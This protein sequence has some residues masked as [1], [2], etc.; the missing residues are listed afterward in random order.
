MD[1]KEI[2]RK[3]TKKYQLFNRSKNNEALNVIN[4]NIK[5]CS[6][7]KKD[8]DINQFGKSKNHEKTGGHSKKCLEC[9][10]KIRVVKNKRPTSYKEYIL[11]AVARGQLTWEYIDTKIITHKEYKD[12]RKTFKK[13]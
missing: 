6:C 10:E 12:A 3:Y 8:L 7:C 9:E 5:T 11:D 1:K 13:N 2:E 4:N